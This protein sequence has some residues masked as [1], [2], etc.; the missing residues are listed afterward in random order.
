MPPHLKPLLA[1]VIVMA[2][3]HTILKVRARAA[4]G[5]A[6]RR[7]AF[8]QARAGADARTTQLHPPDAALA[9]L[10]RAIEDRS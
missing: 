1:V 8:V 5:R 10:R 3:A 2:I 4:A 7:Q 6:R 9:E